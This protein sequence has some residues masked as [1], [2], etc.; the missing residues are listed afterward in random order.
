MSDWQY[1]EL[2]EQAFRA[3]WDEFARVSWSAN[4]RPSH[5]FDP[6][7]ILYDVRDDVAYVLRREVAV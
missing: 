4:A 5:R 2:D 1:K 7:A 3:K 6:N